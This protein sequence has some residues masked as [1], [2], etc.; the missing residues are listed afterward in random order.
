M[1]TARTTGK[2]MNGNTRVVGNNKT[3][4]EFW[5]CIDFKFDLCL[6]LSKEWFKKY[7]DKIR[8]KLGL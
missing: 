6:P 5:S 4:E 1:I 3:E 2:K 8:K 7:I